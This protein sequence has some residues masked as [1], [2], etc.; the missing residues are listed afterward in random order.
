MFHIFTLQG[1]KI[2]SPL[3]HLP[4]N[5]K[6]RQVLKRDMA[7][8][9]IE[10]KSFDQEMA[11]GGHVSY[12][13]DA[14][15]KAIQNENESRPVF[16]AGDIMNFPVITIDPG[17]KASDAWVTFKN[18][19][20]RHMPVLSAEGRIIGIV[21]DRDL[22]KQL[23]I[24]DGTVEDAREVRVK[25]IMADEVITA[26]PLTDIRRI[27]KVMLDHHIG[28][29]PIVDEDGL[30]VGIITRSDILHAIINHPQLKLWA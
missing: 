3:E 15:R 8:K 21:S 24:K 4:Q 9:T 2:D 7:R 17:L 5:V 23:I 30:L 20:V 13:H 19:N 26:S 28:T 25:D 22:M 14:Y 6:V 29:M 16:H 18:A 27:A 12:A 1:K 11:E 10:G